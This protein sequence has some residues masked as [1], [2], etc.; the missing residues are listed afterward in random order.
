MLANGEVWSSA[1]DHLRVPPRVQD[2]IGCDILDSQNTGLGDL[3]EKRDSL[4]I[5]RKQHIDSE[6]PGR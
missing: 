5:I 3:G 2:G 6:H 4:R 1:M